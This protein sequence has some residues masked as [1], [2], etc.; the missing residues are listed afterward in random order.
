[1]RWRR[2][3]RPENDQACVHRLITGQSIIVSIP[4]TERLDQLRAV[5]DWIV[6]A[7]SNSEFPVS[8][9]RA[10]LDE[11]AKHVIPNHG[12]KAKIDIAFEFVNEVMVAMTWCDRPKIDQRPDPHIH[13]G[14]LQ[15]ELDRHSEAKQRANLH[16]HAH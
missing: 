6:W 8:W 14:M 9:L 2:Y 15:H 12:E 10:I 4:S 13:V 5:A 11:C 3:K 1:M 16:R 7:S